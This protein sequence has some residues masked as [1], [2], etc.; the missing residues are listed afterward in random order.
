MHVGAYRLLCTILVVVSLTGAGPGLA[1][2]DVAVLRELRPAQRASVFVVARDG[3]LHI[4]SGDDV[5]LPDELPPPAPAKVAVAP[6]RAPHPITLARAPAA[7]PRPQPP[8]VAALTL[9]R[10]APILPRFLP[11]LPGLLAFHTMPFVPT[12]T[13]PKP[14][15]PVIKTL[16]RDLAW[17]YEHRWD[18]APA[19]VPGIPVR[20][21]V[22]SPF[23][24]DSGAF[25][26]VRASNGFSAVR[27]RVS[28]PC[29]VRHFVTGPGYNEVTNQQG[30]VDLETGYV[31]V[32][33]WGAGP[34][35]VSVDAGLQKSSAQAE[36][37]DYAFYW[38]FDRNKPITA[39]ER[40]PCGGPDVVLELYPV[41][42]TQLVFSATGVTDS[43]E[44]RTLTVVQATNPEDGW[45]PDG[46]S[47]DD[48][49]ILK[50]IISIAQPWTWHRRSGVG[51][52]DRFTSGSYFG[53]NGPHDT[54]PRFVWSQCDVG[55]VVPPAIVPTYR[56]WTGDA[57]WT[58]RAPGIYTDWPPLGVM[59][60]SNES[61]CDAAGLYLHA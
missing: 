39:S 42:A 31:Y 35:G 58:S 7:T 15:L 26:G 43:G 32:G 4:V 8:I 45:L 13:L 2:S 24:I 12:L 33:G 22:S 46:G 38:K 3:S 5:K 36:H 41:S 34:R 30:I 54:T 53:I 59:R 52:N 44:R 57:T 47:H 37:D 60:T 50:R 1:P 49:I 20:S 14:A 55:R 18:E 51:R 11:R 10:V 27:V 29:G 61:V 17:L 19:N 21:Q 48:G 9:P 28:I 25:H 6:T 23:D 56:P 40:F 16:T